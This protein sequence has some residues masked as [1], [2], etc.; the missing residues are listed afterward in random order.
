[1]SAAGRTYRLTEAGKAVR[2]DLS[3]PADYRRILAVLA[4]DTHFDVI[5][6]ALRRYPDKLIGEWVEEIEEI[7][8]IEAV[9]SEADFDLDFTKVLAPAAPAKLTGED[10]KQI[11]AE[12]KSAEAE[13]AKAG[14]WNAEARLRNRPVA[15]KAKADTTVLV[16]FC[17]M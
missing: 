8:Y 16:S 6:G 1:M 13:L 5:R 17:S 11:Q 3:V 15:S 12:A 14:A 10:A 7:G 9:P 2:D 4:T